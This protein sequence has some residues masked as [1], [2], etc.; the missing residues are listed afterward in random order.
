LQ[1]VDTNNPVL[2]LTD[3]TGKLQ[4]LILSLRGIDGQVATEGMVLNVLVSARTVPRITFSYYVGAHVSQ[5]HVEDD[6]RI[7]SIEYVDRIGTTTTIEKDAYFYP[8]Y[9]R[10]VRVTMDTDPPIVWPVPKDGAN[11]FDASRYPHIEEDGGRGYLYR[12]LDP[13]AVTAVSTDYERYSVYVSKPVSVEKVLGAT[14]DIDVEF[15]GG[16]VLLDVCYTFVGR[17]RHPVIAPYP[18]YR[19]VTIGETSASVVE[20]PLIDRTHTSRFPVA[21]GSILSGTYQS[22]G[23]Y[24]YDVIREEYVTDVAARLTNDG[25]IEISDYGDRQLILRYVPATDVIVADSVLL[26]E[27]GD[28]ECLANITSCDVYVRLRFYTWDILH[29]TIV[30]RLRC[31]VF[32]VG[33]G[34]ALHGYLA[35]D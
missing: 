21:S 3:G 4:D 14:V 29:P 32:D 7:H 24:V 11:W 34:R 9:V 15:G 19:T 33:Y 28:H 2:R 30:R 31:S 35:S 1:Y 25:H 6:P 8:V 17:N 10:E 27:S 22:N 5:I 26:T 23:C 18:V 13:P 16:S 12:I 20:E